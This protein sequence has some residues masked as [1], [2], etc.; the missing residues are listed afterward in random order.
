MSP[1]TVK[2]AYDKM[3]EHFA[4]ARARKAATKLRRWVL[5]AYWTGHITRDTLRTTMKTLRGR[6][7]LA[8]RKE[9]VE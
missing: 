3:H 1:K 2:D 9:S 6:R 5:R 4:H 8:S 7:T